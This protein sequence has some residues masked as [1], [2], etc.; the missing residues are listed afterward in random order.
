M[1]IRVYLLIAVLALFAIAFTCKA[2]A[3]ELHILSLDSFALEDYKVNSFQ[4]PYFPYTVTTPEHWTQGAAALFDLDLIKYG[5]ASVYWHNRVH[6]ESTNE[7]VRRV[8]WIFEVGAGITDVV[9]VYWQ[10]DSEHLLDQSSTF[11]HPL[12]NFIGMRVFMY[13]R[14]RDTTK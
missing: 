14:D 5:N 12:S 10:H 7:Q 2:H 11:S 4:D 8:G 3:E 1:F 13:S 9:Q 6:A